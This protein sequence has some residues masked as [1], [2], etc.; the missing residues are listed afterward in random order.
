MQARRNAAPDR[1]AGDD[2]PAVLRAVAEQVARDAAEHLATLP[3]PRQPGGGDVDGAVRTK[4][5]PTDVVTAADESVEAL[6]RAR[7]AELRPG[8]HVFGEEDGGDAARARWVVDPID[9]TVNYLYGLPAYAISIAA[10]LDGRSLAGVVVDPVSGRTWSAAL[11]GGAT[12]DGRPLVVTVETDLAQSLVATGFSYRAERRARQA[13]MAAGMLPLVRDLRRGGSSALDACSVGTG[14]LDGYVEHGLS[15]YDWAA[16]SLIAMEAGA[17]VRVPGP[18]GATPPDD[19][20]G[21]EA[22]LVAAPGIADALAALAREHGAA[23]V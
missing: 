17:V 6:I 4:T 20:L 2:D 10:V 11:G 5:S 16:S 15:W 13:R 7:L 19:G 21:A 9:G 14:W 23:E 8:E 12:L 1:H 18:P 3:P 22:I